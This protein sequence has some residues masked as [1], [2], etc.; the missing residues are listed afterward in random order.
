MEVAILIFLS[1]FLIQTR[2]T[3]LKENCPPP[4]DI[5]ECLCHEVN[6]R[7]SCTELMDPIV[8]KSLTESLA[9]YR[10]QAFEIHDSFLIYLPVEMFVNFHI[11]EFMMN[12]SKLLG[13]ESNEGS[14]MFAGLENVLKKIKFQEIHGISSWRWNVFNV[15]N[16]LTHFAII[17]SDVNKIDDNFLSLKS[18]RFLDLS[19][20]KIKHLHKN[21]FSNLTNLQHFLMNNNEIQKIHRDIF[22]RPAAELRLINLSCNKIEVIPDD[23]FQDMAKLTTVYMKGNKIKFLSPKLFQFLENKPLSTMHLQGNNIYCCSG[24]NDIIIASYKSRLYADCNS[25]QMLKGKP[26]SSLKPSDLYKARC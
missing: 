14:K 18:L 3:K 12:R 7:I 16:T 11:E 25:P 10:V 21:S 22:P 23:F 6:I 15:L 4:E 19:Y 13:F 2:A 17:S 5:P 26:L 8:V 24:L 1:L 9:E 20:N